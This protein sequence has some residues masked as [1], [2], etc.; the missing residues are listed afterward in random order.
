MDAV[1]KVGG[2]LAA[3]PDDLKALGRL[4]CREAKPHRFIV[5]PGGGEF[6]DVVRRLDNR[7]GL[8]PSIA[9]RMAILSMDQYGLFLTDV[10]PNAVATESLKAAQSSWAKKE[11]AILLPSKVLFAENPLPSSWEVTS[12]SIAAYLAVKFK[13]KKVVFVTDVD[14]IFNADP[15]K[16]S[17]SHL[18][19]TVTPLELSR[20][21]DRTSVDNFLP[22]FLLSNALDCYVVNGRFPERVAAILNGKETLC[23]RIPTDSQVS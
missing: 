11:V 21:K 19:K 18:L 5:V 22:K 3:A 17:D 7:I 9:H 23:T 20:F 13:A 15:K 2:S 4:L 6:A 1:V 12:D 16:H 10:F 14:G 8:S